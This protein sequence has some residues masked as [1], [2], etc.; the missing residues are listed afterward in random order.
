MTTSNCFKI[1]LDK[2]G[3]AL[4][5][6]NRITCQDTK[7]LQGGGESALENARYG[8][9]QREFKSVYGPNVFVLKKSG[10]LRLCVDYCELNK[11]L[12]KD[13]YP[14]PRP[15]EAQDCLVGSTVFSTLDLQH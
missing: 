11:R 4:H 7:L 9:H 13:A 2:H 8:S 15:D 1:A 5:P 10:E 12:V 6:Y 3:Q 14:L